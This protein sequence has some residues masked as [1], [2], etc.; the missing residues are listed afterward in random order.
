MNIAQLFKSISD[1]IRLRILRI[2]LR[3]SFNVNEILLIIGGKQSNIS[4][5]LRILRQN[6]LVLNRKEGSQIYYR[7]NEYRDNEL[8]EDIIGFIKSHTALIPLY[9]ED[10]QRLEGVLSRRQKIAEE[11][12]SLY[13]ENQKQSEQELFDRLY[14]IDEFIDFFSP[15]RENLLDVGCG[16]GRHLIKLAGF[17]KKVIGIDGSPR[18]IQLSD[19]NCRENGLNYELK[20]AD[21]THLPFDDNQIDGI[22]VNMV[23]H[24]LAEPAQGITEIARVLTKGGKLLFIDFLEHNDEQMREKYADLWLG[25]PRELL[26]KWLK[27]Q[28]LTVEKE[29]IKENGSHKAIILMAIKN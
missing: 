11:Y 9:N 1:D 13:D 8:I 25:F 14:S 4:H 22:F 15:S 24:H 19:H 18:M 21:V 5:H 3:G 28:H 26:L 20:L 29:V 2:L 17:S 16:N 7:L 23:L 10:K 27:K 12:F 6:S